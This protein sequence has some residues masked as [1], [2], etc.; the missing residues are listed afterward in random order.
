[1]VPSGFAKIILC[2]CFTLLSM[3]ATSSSW[4]TSDSCMDLDP[5]EFYIRLQSVALP[6]LIDTRSSDEFRKERIEGAILAENREVLNIVCDTLDF[7]QAIFLYC[8]DDYRSKEAC[9]TLIN[10]GFKNVCYLRGGIVAWKL[11]V[12]EVD[13]EKI[14]R[15]RARN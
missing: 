11:S 13:R 9:K 2:S 3:L 8:Q 6:V 14:R 5:G 10:R 15:K 7:D 4:H 12:F 1:M